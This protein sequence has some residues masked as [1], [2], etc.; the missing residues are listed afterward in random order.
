[1]HG[2]KNDPLSPGPDAGNK[3]NDHVAGVDGGACVTGRE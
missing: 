2:M 3:A 1:M